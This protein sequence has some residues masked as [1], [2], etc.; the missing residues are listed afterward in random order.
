V[1]RETI[2]YFG[3]VEFHPKPAG[4]PGR[5]PV[6]LN[7]SYP[8]ASRG[9]V[10]VW[11]L[12]STL[13]IGGIVWQVLHYLVP[14]RRLGFDVWYVEDSYRPTYDMVSFSLLADLADSREN[15]CRV[16]RFLASVGMG[17]RWV[18]RPMGREPIGAL[19]ETG[20]DRLYADAAFAINLCGAEDLGE[21]QK[22][23]PCRVYLETDPVGSQVLVAQGDAK[24]IRI[25]DDHH[26]HFTYGG[27]FGA[28]DCRVPLG[29]YDWIKTVPPVCLD[30]WNSAPPPPPDAPLTT[31]LNWRHKLKD[32]QWNG[33][34]WRWTKDGQFSRFL[35]LPS[36]SALPLEMC[37]GGATV[38]D[39]EEISRHGW[40]I[41]RSIDYVEP[42][43][44][45]DYIRE[46]AGE[47]SAA[48]ELVVVTRSGWFSDRTVCFL[49][50]GRPAI[51]QETGFSNFLPTG[52]GLFGFSSLEEAAAAIEAVAADYQRHS[53]AA[54]DIAH[55]YFDADR[56]VGKILENVGAL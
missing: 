18:C 16:G 24:M 13:P 32:V 49:A 27:N 47:F 36:R 45:R 21:R 23:V 28:D 41:K 42:D 35:S 38:S 12:L 48:K 51:V 3:D 4:Q 19:D 46:S 56:V 8:P 29:R 10:V 7:L 31:V 34:A 26:W 39:L 9:Q 55:E 37:V 54:R 44:Y 6:R 30:L 5:L 40:S 11:G 43:R 2:L 25:L 33:E 53:C 22:A 17:D 1:V 50:A 52:T 14:L 20:L 15:I